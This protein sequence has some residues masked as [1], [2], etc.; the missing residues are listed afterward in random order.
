MRD[1]YA[2]YRDLSLKTRA[3]NGM[4]SAF[5]VGPLERWLARR[6]QGAST[7]SRIAKMIPHEYSYAKNSWRT[8]RRNG[9]LFELDL[10]NAV[11]HCIY[12][13]LADP[14]YVNLFAQIKSSSRVIDV[15][16]NIGMLTLPFARAA[17]DGK[18]VSFEPDPATH[19]RLVDHI[20]MNGISNVQVECKGLGSE[21]KMHR[22][23]RVVETNAGMNRITLNDDGHSAFPYS[24]VRVTTLDGVWPELGLDRVDV[25]KLDV[26]GFEMEVLRGAERTLRAYWPVLFIE[27]DDDNLRENGSSAAGLVNFLTDIGYKLKHAVNLAPLRVEGLAHCHFDILGHHQ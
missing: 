21:E 10:S 5:K 14:G 9:F 16:A 20:S 22:L 18:I 4:R 1:N 24:E 19:R 6:T 13:G 7:T 12:F 27:L 17:Q 23:Y 26:E 2:Y 8:A 15:G 11:D 25:I 3:L